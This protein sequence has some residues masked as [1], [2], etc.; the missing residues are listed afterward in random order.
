M[1]RLTAL[2]IAA[3][4][5]VGLLAAPAAQAEW[6][7]HDDDRKGGWD[8]GHQGH[9]GHYR[10]E[11]HYRHH[12][13]GHNGALTGAL[14]GLGA[15]AVIGGV[16][17]AQPNYAQP[18]YAQ[19]NYAQPYY[20]QQYYAPPPPVVYAPP[21]P[22]YRGACTVASPQAFFKSGHW[23]T[24][25]ASFLY[26]DFCFAVWVLNGRC[27]DRRQLRVGRRSAQY[28]Q[29]VRN[30]RRLHVLTSGCVPRSDQVRADLCEYFV[31]GDS[32]RNEVSEVGVLH[33]G[34]S[35]SSVVGSFC[36]ERDG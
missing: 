21:H 17:A 19:P 13:G 33:E 29:R 7:G 24:L 10:S 27:R 15:L 6:R 14:L 16:F 23:P 32:E 28:Q 31:V 2:L 3:P 25:L 11:G 18:N 34:D 30:G 1:A 22:P 26:F 36:D 8:R 9:H 20:A 5:A 12:G 35:P 4:V